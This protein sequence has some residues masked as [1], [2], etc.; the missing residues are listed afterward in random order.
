MKNKY[1]FIIIPPD[2]GKARQ[3]QLSQKRKKA[4]LS[5]VGAICLFIISLF[6]YNIY[7]NHQL[8]GQEEQIALIEELKTQN[9]AK[10]QEIARLQ[11]EA[12]QVALDISNIHEL[13]LK[14]MAILN[15]DEKDLPAINQASSQDSLGSQGSQESVMTAFANP[16]RGGTSTLP[17]FLLQNSSEIARERQLLEEYYKIALENQDVIERTPSIYPI[18]GEIK[19][20]SEFGRRKNPFGGYSNE[21]HNGVDF[22]CNYGTEVYATGKGVVKVSGYN[23][24]YGRTIEIDHGN[25]IETIYAHNS[26]LLVKVG[27]KIEKGQLIAYS[28]NSGRSTGAHLHYGVRVNG[29]TVDPLK[30]I[31][32]EKEQ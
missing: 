32:F 19:I 10:D 2:H 7:L 28:G 27:D 9:Q 8:L 3:F 21:F 1:T 12:Q 13:E 24:V 22:P 25:G 20:S 23:R 31:N 16:S 17:P 30:F 4:L 6:S 11:D 5:G 14:L 15:L 18:K 29:K 26:R